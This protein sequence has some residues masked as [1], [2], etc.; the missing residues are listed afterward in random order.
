[1]STTSRSG[2][3]QVTQA[4]LQQTVAQQFQFGHKIGR[5]IIDRFQIFPFRL[6]HCLSLG[7]QAQQFGQHVAD[8]DPERFVTVGVEDLI[9]HRDDLRIRFDGAAQRCRHFHQAR[10]DAH[11]A[12]QILQ[13]LD[14]PAQ[15]CRPMLAKSIAG[16]VRGHEGIAVLI[17]ADPGTEK[18]KYRQLRTAAVAGGQGTLQIAVYSRNGLPDSG[19]KKVQPLLHL[20]AYPQTLGA[21]LIGGQQQIDLLVDLLQGLLP[22]VFAQIFAA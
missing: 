5:G 18:K 4:A 9:R 17:A 13:R 14:M 1:M 15:H 22:L 8:L 7:L 11:F 19:H 3:D 10:R 2:A 12:V 16:D 6:A 21:H 20:I